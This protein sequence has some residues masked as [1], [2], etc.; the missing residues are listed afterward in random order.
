MFRFRSLRKALRLTPW[1]IL[2]TQRDNPNLGGLVLKL[3]WRSDLLCTFDINLYKQSST[4]TKIVT[5]IIAASGGLLDLVSIM[6]L[7]EYKSGFSLAED[8]GDHV[9]RYAILSHIWGEDTEVIFRDLTDSTGRSKAGYDKLR[10]CG[11]Q[12]KRDGLQ[13]FW[14]NTCCIDKS[15]NTELSEAIKSMFRWGIVMRLNATTM[16]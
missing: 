3:F 15:N 12:V 8:F 7:L 9:L 6:R 2:A 5:T 10:F 1:G 13:Y 4:Y 16:L 11:E 14:V